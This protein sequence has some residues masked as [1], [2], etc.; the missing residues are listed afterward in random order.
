METN[1][2]TKIC[3]QCKKEK[4]IK[5][6]YKLTKTRLRPECKSCT[7]KNNKDYYKLNL[8]II[9]WRKNKKKIGDL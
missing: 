1:N 9:K 4:S 7:S 8:E 6:F 5:W 3:L 2:Q